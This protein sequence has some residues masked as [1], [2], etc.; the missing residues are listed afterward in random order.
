M[1]S[2]ALG[3]GCVKT[4]VGEFNKKDAALFMGLVSVSVG[5]GIEIL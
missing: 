3:E 2:T 5:R 1:G 4:Y